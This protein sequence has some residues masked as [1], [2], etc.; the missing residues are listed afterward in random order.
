MFVLRQEPRVFCWCLQPHCCHCQCVVHLCMFGSHVNE[1][2]VM[3]CLE[4][5]LTVT[6]R[7]GQERYAS[8]ALVVQAG[9]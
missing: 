5:G 8:Y 3:C 2:E 7:V 4:H 6:R 1:F 9:Y